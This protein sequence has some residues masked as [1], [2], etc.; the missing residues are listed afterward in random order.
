MGSMKKLVAVPDSQFYTDLNMIKHSLEM[1]KDFYKSENVPVDFTFD[2]MIKGIENS[3]NRGYN[4][5]CT[6]AEKNVK[7]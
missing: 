2:H 7:K 5:S 1:M 4:I 6:G 3:I